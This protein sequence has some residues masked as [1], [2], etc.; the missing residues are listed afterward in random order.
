MLGNMKIWDLKKLKDV[1]I[2]NGVER[3][4]NYWF[5]GADIEK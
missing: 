4:K 3:I 1:V 5:W 2:P